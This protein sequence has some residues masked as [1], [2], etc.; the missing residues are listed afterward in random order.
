VESESDEKKDD[1]DSVDTYF[2]SVELDRKRTRDEAL[3][4][5]QGVVDNASASEEAKN[6]ALAE[7]SVIAKTMETESNIET[8]IEA[9]G[10]EECVAVIKNDSASIVVKSEGLQAA[11]ISQINEIVYEQAGISPVNVKIIQR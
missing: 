1:K 4:V 5:L 11:Q 10:F 8:I 2:S 7:I 9:K 6:E 3:E